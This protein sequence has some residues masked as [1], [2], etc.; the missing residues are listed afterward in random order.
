MPNGFN[1]E[2]TSGLWNPVDLAGHP[3][4]PTL[5]ER[6][7]VQ[8]LDARDA[9]IE[10]DVIREAWIQE[11]PMIQETL[12]D[13]GNYPS[14]ETGFTQ[15]REPHDSGKQRQKTTCFRKQ[16]PRSHAIQ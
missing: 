14:Q 4:D 16:H 12:G 10:L 1:L 9:Q 3:M 11:T 7:A 15:F 8:K 2:G 13:A 5:H 6:R